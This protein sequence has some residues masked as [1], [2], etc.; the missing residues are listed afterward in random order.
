MNEADSTIWR[1]SGK[2]F[3]KRAV[4]AS[5]ITAVVLSGGGL[6]FNLLTLDLM[7]LL[8]ALA[9]LVLSVFFYMFVF[10]EWQKW[11]THR[12]DEWRLTSAALGFR[13]L[14][15]GMAFSDLP[16]SEI[17]HVKLSFWR[18]V[19]IR[20]NSGRAFHMSYLAEPKTVKALIDA[21]LA[22][23]QTQRDAANG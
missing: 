23:F 15:E 5:T 11:N 1:A 9:I 10:D 14:D 21:K 16:F 13:N 6:L 7:G 17:K 8:T 4:L 18:G 19:R 20:L 3:L 22:A 12:R 2:V